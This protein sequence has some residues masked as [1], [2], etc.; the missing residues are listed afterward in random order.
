MVEQAYNPFRIAQ[1]QFEQ[2]AAVLNLDQGAVDFLRIPMREYHFSIPLKMDSGEVKVFRGYRILHNDAR[3]PAKGGIRFHPQETADTVRALAMWMTW[4]TAVADLPLGGSYGSVVCDPHDL[5]RT[6]Q[7]RLSRGWVRGLA[8]NLG[9]INDIPEP[10]VMTNSKHMLWMLDE[11]EVLRGSKYPGF[12]TGK[13][14]DLGGSKGRME[15]A[16]YGVVIALREALKE[17][18]IDPEQTTASFQGFGTVARHAIELYQQMGGIVTTVSCWNQNDQTSYAVR[19]PEGINLPELE[20]ISNQFGEIDIEEAE[21]LGYERLPGDEWLQ[22]KVDILIPAALENQITAES[23]K[24][25]RPS[26]KLIVEGANGPLTPEADFYL[27]ENKIRVIPDMLANAGG[28]IS[29]YFEQVQSNNN[30]YWQ[31]SEVLGQLDV[32]MTSAFINVSDFAK[33]QETTLREAAYLI[34]VE[35]VSRACSKRGWI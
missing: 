25:I 21:K 28:V 16:G 23:V 34:A 9:P 13:P 11:Y 6:E 18:G 2:A 22:Q 30:Y 1:E 10:D 14:V 33:K 19:K 4:K 24:N 29:S 32:K 27:R 20:K 7:E 8:R 35:R 26:V 5:T 17:L 3:G 15:S 12:I 31:K